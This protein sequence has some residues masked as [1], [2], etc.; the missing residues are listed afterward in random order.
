MTRWRL[1]ATPE[2]T[3]D[4]LFSFVEDAVPIPFADGDVETLFTLRGRTHAMR[5]APLRA[6]RALLWK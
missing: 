1:C 5:L 6:M 4:V 2:L 3:G